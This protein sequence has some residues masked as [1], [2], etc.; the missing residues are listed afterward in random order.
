MTLWSRL[1]LHDGRDDDDVQLELPLGVEECGPQPEIGIVL[2]DRSDSLDCE[3]HQGGEGDGEASSH[4]DG[5]E[6]V[7]L[8]DPDERKRRD[9][10][11]PLYLTVDPERPNDHRRGRDQ[12][13][14]P[15][16]H[17][18]PLSGYHRRHRG[19][20]DDKNCNSVPEEGHQE[21]FHDCESHN[22]R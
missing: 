8:D 21:A 17:H 18:G 3:G 12:R 22:A 2:G 11:I 19:D 10:E 5:S 6:R 4:F 1:E 20:D 16:N 15:G 7:E 9:S 14:R 13:E